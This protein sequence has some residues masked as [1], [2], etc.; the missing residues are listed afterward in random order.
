MAVVVVAVDVVVELSLLEES[1]V[2]VLSWSFVLSVL[3]VLSLLFLLLSET[4]CGGV[5]SMVIGCPA[6]ANTLVGTRV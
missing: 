3:S 6:M 5:P 2:L 4:D 1:L